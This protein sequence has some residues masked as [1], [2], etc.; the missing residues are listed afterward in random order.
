M[1]LAAS[2]GRPTARAK[3]DPAAS[4]G[5]LAS[6]PGSEKA[7]VETMSAFNSLT[8]GSRTGPRDPRTGAGTG[9]AAPD[10]APVSVLPL[11]PPSSQAS[12]AMKARTTSRSAS[13][14]SATARE[15]APS[16][17]KSTRS[18]AR[19]MNSRSC[20]MTSAQRP[21]SRRAPTARAQA[22]MLAQSSP[23]VGSSRITRGFCETSAAATVTRCFCPPDSD[24]GWSSRTGASPSSSRASSVRAALSASPSRPRSSSARTLSV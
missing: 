13:V 16:S 23:L 4:R 7:S 5:R 3:S 1:N 12:P 17:M 14:S 10:S 22:A 19:A 6:R 8:R 21:A 20:V 2:P 15:I 18:A 24:C 11:P 9:S